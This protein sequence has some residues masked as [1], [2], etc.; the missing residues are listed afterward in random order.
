LAISPRLSSSALPID[1]CEQGG[2]DVV[3]RHDWAENHH[4][5]GVEDADGSRLARAGLP[6]GI[7]GLTRLH[8][9]SPNT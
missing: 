3:H 8:D 6:E 7:A 1:R 4:D 2:A 9:R 5:V